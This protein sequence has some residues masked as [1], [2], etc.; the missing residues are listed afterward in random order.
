MSEHSVSLY[1][2]A[3]LYRKVSGKKILAIY[4]SKV[5]KLFPSLDR[6]VFLSLEET[7]A[8]LERFRLACAGLHH[9]TTRIS[10][11]ELHSELSVIRD[12]GKN[13]Y[14]LIDEDWKYCGLL[15]AKEIGDLNVAIEFD[16]KISNDL[17]FISTD[18]SQAFNFDF[19]EMDG[20]RLVDVKKWWKE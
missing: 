18:M 19:F 1:R 16:E 6:Q 17:V 15:E 10:A 2:K 12:S 7:D 20:H 11:D 14:V 8:F 5:A 4:L 3:L 13:F 9:G